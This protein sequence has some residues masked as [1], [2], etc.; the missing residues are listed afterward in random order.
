MALSN[1]VMAIVT[2]TALMVV[3]YFFSYVVLYR[4]LLPLSA[5]LPSRKLGRQLFYLLIMPGTVI[6]ELSH[7]AACKLSRVRVF[8]VRLF[9]PQP[10]GVVGQVVYER[11]DPLRRNLIAFAPFLG[12]ALALYVSIVNAI[13]ERKQ[14]TSSIGY[15]YL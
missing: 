2:T 11:C 12:G 3:L 4:G 9:D 10:S 6:H 5:T 7:L 14:D 8:E 15:A 13:L 1:L